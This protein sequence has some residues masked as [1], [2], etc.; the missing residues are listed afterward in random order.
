MATSETEESGSN[1]EAEQLLQG[2]RDG[3][4][5]GNI[6]LMDVENVLSNERFTNNRG[7][8]ATTRKGKVSLILSHLV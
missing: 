7:L 3:A 2:V 1:S 5:Y 8:L 6:A 4:R